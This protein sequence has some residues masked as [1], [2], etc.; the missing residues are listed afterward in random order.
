MIRKL[1]I[2]SI[3]L[4]SGILLMSC[5]NALQESDTSKT[6]APVKVTHL[7][8]M[9]MV[10]T[11]DLNANT[12]FLN[13]E[14]VRA[15]FQGFIQEIHKNIGDEVHSG[16]L[17]LKV[18]TKESAVD[19]SLLFGD[20]LFQGAVDIRAQS[21][22][23]LTT[24]NYHPGDFVS[25]GEE[26]AIISNPSS[27]RIHLNVPY[28]FVSRINRHCPCMIFLPDGETV[29]ASVQKIIPSVDPVS[30][31]QTFLLRP[32]NPIDLPENL[33]VNARLPLSTIKNAQVLPLSAVQSNETQDRF[34]VMKLMNDT[35]AVRMDIDK[36]LESDSVVQILR[37]LLQLTDAFISEGAYG[38]PDTAA[39]RLIR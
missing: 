5:G 26:I 22:G 8:R 39:V 38:L 23:A 28:P 36:G 29:H 6:G 30:Q 37:P 18:K 7:R 11:I 32:N 27:L 17:L 20:N 12:V 14:I 21:N 35:T 31:T 2:H 3:I 15:T 34:W 25:E 9:D 10:E 13:K 16:D 4:L 33:N 19:S 24:L 1:W